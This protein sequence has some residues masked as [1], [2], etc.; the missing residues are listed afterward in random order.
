MT[1]HPSK[2]PLAT[3]VF[4]TK[5]SHVHN[6]SKP[7]AN[8]HI[9]SSI[10]N[11][12][13]DSFDFTHFF[14]NQIFRGSRTFVRPAVSP[15]TTTVK[16]FDKDL[17]QAANGL[18]QSCSLCS[19]SF[20]VEILSASCS[21]LLEGKIDSRRAR[22]PASQN[23]CFVRQTLTDKEKRARRHCFSLCCQAWRFSTE[24]GLLS[25]SRD[26]KKKTAKNTTK[27]FKKK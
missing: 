4:C 23:S 25:Q 26:G 6:Y 13:T 14:P 21:S 20:G 7:S 10:W 11:L 9:F 24:L 18:P 19:R 5:S 12:K 8:G 16:I 17:L 1:K 2:G 27:N 3:E 15:P 22:V